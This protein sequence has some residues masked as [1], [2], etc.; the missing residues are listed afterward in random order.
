MDDAERV[1]AAE[2]ERDGAWAER[3]R[4]AAR[5]AAITAA[6]QAE[7]QARK[8]HEASMSQETFDAWGKAKNEVARLLAE[9][10]DA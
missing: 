4:L 9:L 5:L 1:Y 3:D 8:T 6:A 10:G 2:C 7:T